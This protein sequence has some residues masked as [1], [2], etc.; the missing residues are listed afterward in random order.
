MAANDTLVLTV[1]ADGDAQFTVDINGQQQGGT[2]DA[3]AAHGT[4]TTAANTQDITLTGD[5]ST[6]GATQ[7]AVNFL[8]Q[9]T[10]DLYV[11]SIN[12]DGTVVQGNQ[13]VMTPAS[14][15][16]GAD[17][18]AAV[19]FEDGTA[20]FTVGGTPPTTSL[21]VAQEQSI[22]PSQ[23]VALTSLFSANEPDGDPITQYNIYEGSFGTPVG[24]VTDA[25]GNVLPT[26]QNDTV[27]SLGGI[28]YNSSTNAGSDRLWVQA[29]ADGQWGNWTFVD[30]NNTGGSGGSGGSGSG[31]GGGVVTSGTGPI[32]MVMSADGDAQFTVDVN[33]T[34]VGGVFDVTAAHGTG[35]TAANTQTVTLPGDFSTSGPLQVSVNFTNQATAD[36]YIESVTADG[37]TIQ[38]NQAAMTPAS[39]NPAADPNAAVM[40]EDGTATFNIT[41]TGGSGAGTG[42]NTPPTTSLQVAQEQSVGPNQTVALTNLF[43]A[44]EPDGDP[45]TQYNIY[46]GSFGTPVGTV[47]DANGN[48]LPT[49]QNDTVTSLAGINYNSSM[50]AGSDRLWVQAFAD[51]Q[52]G[53]WTFVDMNNAGGDPPATSLQVAQEQS[54]G[55][56][57]TVALT[58]LFSANEPDGDPIT[59]Y[60][61]Y[62][63]SFGTP[64]GTVT[65]ANGN[66]LPTFQNDTV[67]SLAGINYNSSTNAGSDRLWVQAFAD[68]QWGNWTFVD[69]NNTGDPSG[70]GGTPPTTSLQVAQEQSIGPSQ[71]VA[72]SSLFSANEPDGDPITQ[73][74]IYEGSFGTPVGTVTDANGNVLPTFQNDTVTSL[75]GINYNSSTNAGSDR[76]WVQAFADG[77]WGNWTFVD[78]NNTGGSAGSGGGGGGGTGPISMVMSADGDAQFTVDVNGTQV[79][80]VFDVTAAHGT[81]TTAANT[82]T[83]TLPGDFSTTGP[84]QVAVNF[85]NQATADLYIE[86]ITA[87]G[88]TIQGNQ[89]AMTPASTN[90]AADPNAAVMFENGTATFSIAPLTQAIAATTSSGSGGSSGGSGQVNDQTQ[91][92]LAVSHG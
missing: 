28:N 10:A 17:P 80:G 1:S 81:G 42:G 20:T 41:G 5:F 36:L 44:N 22:G 12:F 37:Q 34:Q 85:T 29:F 9:A 33:G 54:I 24:T 27:T 58:S 7:I 51:G 31:G 89:A 64:V 25:N 76:L 69:M 15:N 92:G 21:Q 35:T 56:S 65:D 49:F 88:Q 67:T 30:M 83:V 11:E 52:W 90:P 71:T 18:N 13:A 39:T 82:Q 40:F 68:G 73:Y 14:T 45:I 66:V 72:L 91:A 19:M 70:G 50:N 8:N 62:E 43:S 26:F 74:N 84:L 48:V 75:A 86:S 23:T 87:D 55:P 59:Q 53:N 46:E 77:Q 61:I 57:Q 38:G 32:S 47:T 4:G 16:P 78:M 6:G 79:G 63:G 2:F 60:N 3:T